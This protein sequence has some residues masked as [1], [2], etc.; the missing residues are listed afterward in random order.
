M[1]ANN[2]TD[3]IGDLPGSYDYAESKVF[4]TEVRQLWAK[5]M[6]PL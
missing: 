6:A 4:V 1:W 3:Y 2:E 5:K